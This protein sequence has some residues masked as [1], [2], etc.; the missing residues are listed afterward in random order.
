MANRTHHDNRYHLPVHIYVACYNESA[1]IR[2]TFDFYRRQF[3][4]PTFYL[5]DNH[6]TDDSVAIAKTYG[7]TILP[8]G[9]KTRKDNKA[10]VHA[11]NTAW[12]A[13]QQPRQPRWVGVNSPNLRLF[14]A[15]VMSRSCT[16]RQLTI[17]SKLVR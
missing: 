7:A 1:M 16:K 15:F 6:S 3:G 13:H 8:W 11:K 4:Q 14:E 12:K 2:Q 5:L 9:H 17:S 10:L